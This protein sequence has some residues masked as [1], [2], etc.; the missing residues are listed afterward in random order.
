[1]ATYSNDGSG[2]QTTAP[3]S[4]S[5]DNHRQCHSWAPGSE[6]DT[7][8]GKKGEEST[9]ETPSDDEGEETTGFLGTIMEGYEYIADHAQG[10]ASDLRDTFVDGYGNFAENASEFAHDVGQAIADE[11]NDYRGVFLDGLHDKDEGES[12]I[13]EMGMARNLSLLPSDMEMFADDMTQP[14]E[15]ADYNIF[16]APEPGHRRVVSQTRKFID[17][18]GQQQKVSVERTIYTGVIPFHAYITLFIAVI[19]LSSIG[20]SLDMQSNVVPSMKIFWRMTATYV[21]LSPLAL[22]SIYKDGFPKLTYTQTCTFA[23]TAFCYAF[24][25]VAFVIA[26]EYTSVGNVVIFSNR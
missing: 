6:T 12:V 8:L 24:F 2:N 21:V 16:P 11:A 13:Y 7:L 5:E 19:A 14:D 9:H 4:S 3:A 20:P 25:C 22:R 10:A 1:M 17:E 15:Y 18:E 26:L 23:M